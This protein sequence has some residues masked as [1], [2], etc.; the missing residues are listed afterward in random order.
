MLNE[1][2]AEESSYHD[3]LVNKMAKFASEKLDEQAL[4]EF[5]EFSESSEYFDA[6]VVPE[7]EDS[8]EMVGRNNRAIDQ[9]YLVNRW[10][11]GDDAG[12][13]TENAIRDYPGVWVV[14]PRNRGALYLQWRYA[15]LEEQISEVTNLADKYNTCRARVKQLFREKEAH[16]LRQKR[17]IGCT[18]T[19]AA[20]YTEDIRKASPGIVLV[21]EAGEILESHVL[22]A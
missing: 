4:L 9:H 13:F 5:L 6:F 19:A 11:R 20:M 21:E 14:E 7:S 2:K 3:A 8:M 16:V 15:I 1:Q 12:V 17:V 18:T 22:T 10:L